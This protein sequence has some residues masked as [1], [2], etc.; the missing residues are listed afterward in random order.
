MT[1]VRAR[2]LPISLVLTLPMPVYGQSAPCAEVLAGLQQDLLATFPR[3]VESIQRDVHAVH[4]LQWI[5]IDGE[6]ETPEVL[7]SVLGPASIAG[8]S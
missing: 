8:R 1:S 4:H 7:A 3:H 2:L 5:G 6:S